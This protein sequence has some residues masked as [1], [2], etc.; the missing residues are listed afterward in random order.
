MKNLQFSFYSTISVQE[1]STIFLLRSFQVLVILA[2]TSTIV[3]GCH[4]SNVLNENQIDLEDLP[5]IT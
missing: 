3:I 5:E 1:K 2:L 4:R